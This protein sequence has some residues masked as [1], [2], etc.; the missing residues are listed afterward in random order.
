MILEFH[1][2]NTFLWLVFFLNIQ[3]FSYTFICANFPKTFLY[4]RITQIQHF[5]KLFGFHKINTFFWLVF[6]SKNST[7]LIHLYVQTF[8]KHF[9]ILE[10][11]KFNTFLNFWIS[12]NQHFSLTCIFF[13]TF[14]LYLYMCKLSQ[15]QHFLCILEF[16]TISLCVQHFSKFLD[17]RISQ[18]QHFFL[19]CIFSKYSTIL[20]HLYVQTFQ[21]HFFIL[22]LHKFNTFLNFWISQNQHFSL[23]CIFFQHFS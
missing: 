20:I 3:H 2:I 22:E 11:H 6:F 18:N 4:F 13:S 23:T 1:K 5:S 9:F 14:F 12:Q 8:Q 17:F 7:I 21:K 15:N 10:L 16:F 19:T